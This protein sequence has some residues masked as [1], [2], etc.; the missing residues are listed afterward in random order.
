MLSLQSCLTLCDPMDNSPWAY[1]SKNTGVG[2][3]LLLQG[4][5]P[6]QGSNPGLL[7]L[8]HWQADS[9]TTEPPGIRS[10]IPWQIALTKIWL[11]WLL[12]FLRN[13][14]QTVE[15]SLCIF[16]SHAKHLNTFCI[17]RFYNCWSVIPQH[18]LTQ[19]GWEHGY[20]QVVSSAAKA[21]HNYFNWLGTL[22]LTREP[23]NYTGSI[24]TLHPLIDRG[25][26][27]AKP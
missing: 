13:V 27:C 7:C 14:S 8:L 2:C 25:L 18:R 22:R 11:L 15:D 17:P 23:R 9:L 21:R 5:F 16:N 26:T 6:T 20:P 12:D 4:I 3:H 19:P 10:A 24:V 1:P